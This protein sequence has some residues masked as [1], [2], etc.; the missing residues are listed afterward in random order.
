VGFAVGDWGTESCSAQ[1]FAAIGDAH[2][3]R[4]ASSL[5]ASSEMRAKRVMS[6]IADAPKSRD[7]RKGNWEVMMGR[8]LV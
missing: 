7:G 2:E 6:V 4:Q 8:R 5:A 1:H 3:N